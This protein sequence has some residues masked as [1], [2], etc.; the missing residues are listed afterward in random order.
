[1]QPASVPYLER[2]GAFAL[3]CLAVL[4]IVAVVM[5]LLSWP[6]LVASEQAREGTN[7]PRPSLAILGGACAV[8]TISGFQ[9]ESGGR[10][11]PMAKE[12]AAP[13]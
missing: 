8:S 10:P 6:C 3:A 9:P 2:T 13:P 4:L 12:S 5:A 11:A 1:M 7:K